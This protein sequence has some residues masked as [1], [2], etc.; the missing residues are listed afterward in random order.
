MRRMKSCTAIFSLLL[1][2]SC[3][4]KDES[5]AD[6]S[7][8]TG[9]LTVLVNAPSPAFVYYANAPVP[10]EVVARLDGEPI[11]VSHATWSLD[12]GAQEREGASGDFDAMAVGDHTVHVEVL[13]A[14]L[15]DVRDVTFTV[16]PAESDT[17]T[18]TDA[19]TDADSDADTDTEFIGTIDAT[20]DYH[21]DFGDFGSPCPGTLAMTLM[22][23]GTIRGLG[24]CNATESD[25]DF[26]F[27][28]DLRRPVRG[29]LTAPGEPDA[30]E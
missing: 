25:V 29:R 15:S 26:P 17:D 9:E 12:D 28:L 6:D 27:T 23:D 8:A 2:V 5:S 20:I 19:D 16:S 21:G 22:A 10:F 30:A 4:G 14:G 24:T 3:S 11:D 7:A 1:L 13:A 18:D